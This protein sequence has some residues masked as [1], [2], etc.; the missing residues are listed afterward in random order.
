[1]QTYIV[2]EGRFS[3]K[4]VDGIRD[5][6]P[7]GFPE[8]CQWSKVVFRDKGSVDPFSN[9]EAAEK[10]MLKCKELGIDVMVFDGPAY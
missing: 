1:M 7:F 5:E 3:E 8:D 9:R 2:K 4:A 6:V 10:C